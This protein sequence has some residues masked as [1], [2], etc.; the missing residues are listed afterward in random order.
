[1]GFSVCPPQELNIK[2]HRCQGGGLCLQIY[3]G[4]KYPLMNQDKGVVRRAAAP[5]WYVTASLKGGGKDPKLTK[6]RGKQENND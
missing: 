3:R 5:L 2:I 1:M 6:M 4:G